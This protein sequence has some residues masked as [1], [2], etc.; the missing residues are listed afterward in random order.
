M[1]AGMRGR[2]GNMKKK[3]SAW[4]HAL[5]RWP[6]PAPCWRVARALATRPAATPLTAR[7]TLTVGFDQS[8]PPYGFVGD[9]G[10]YTGLTW[11]WLRPC[12]TRTA[13]S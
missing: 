13:G 4:W 5:P 3:P 8:Y 11:I 12:A 6:C 10:K 7:K 2:E 9:D 1:P